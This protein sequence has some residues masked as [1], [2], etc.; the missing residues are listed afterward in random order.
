MSVCLSA[1]ISLAPLNRWARNFVCGSPVVVSLSSSGG[2]ALRYVLPVLWMTSPLAVMGATPKG[3]GW[4]V[5]QLPWTAWRYRGGVWCPWMLV[6]FCVK[7]GY[8][9]FERPSHIVDIPRTSRRY[10]NNNIIQSVYIYTRKNSLRT[11]ILTVVGC[12]HIV[13]CVVFADCI[14]ACGI[15]LDLQRST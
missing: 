1:S 5:S 3:G 4:H 8:E 13:V 12:G 15:Y 7:R 9:L 2:V 14:S 10:Q 11:V 6:V